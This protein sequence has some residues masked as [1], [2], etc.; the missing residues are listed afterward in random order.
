M[1]DLLSLPVVYV[2]WILKKENI[3]KEY[4]AIGNYEN[5]LK[6]PQTS[7]ILMYLLLQSL[8]YMI[9]HY[10][11]YLVNSEDSGKL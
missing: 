1:F 10:L 11:Y 3:R 7:V 4:I 5:T 9:K 2:L 6:N 8:I